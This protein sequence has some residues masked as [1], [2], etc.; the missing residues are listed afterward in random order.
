[1]INLT[2]MQEFLDVVG[3]FEWILQD[4]GFV[5]FVC[6]CDEGFIGTKYQV[7]LL[8]QYCF[9]QLYGVVFI[10]KDI[11]FKDGIVIGDEQGKFFIL[12]DV[13]DFLGMC[14][15]CINYDCYLM[16]K[17]KFSIGFV[18]FLGQL[19][20][21][22]YVYNQ[23]IFIE[24]VQKMIKSLESK[25]L[26]LQLLFVYFRENVISC[27]VTNDFFNEIIVEQC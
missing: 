13:D 7:G 25:C 21:C 9:F 14:G 27:D 24:D 8:E 18:F 3:Q 1:M 22:N 11:L 26:C 20:S 23:Y 12:F 6:V 2:R 10:V 17:T 15:F 5:K 16:D 19:L 4:S